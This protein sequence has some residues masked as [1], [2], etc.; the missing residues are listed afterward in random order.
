[1]PDV[2]A[3]VGDPT[4]RGI[5]ER[6][7]TEGPLS[8]SALA[9]SL[10]MSRQAVTKHLD[11]LEGAGLIERHVRGRERMHVL[12]AHPLR[13]LNDWLAPYEAEWDDRLARLRSHL[14]GEKGNGGDDD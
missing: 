2:F 13:E 12:S 3:A 11:V 1:M 14:A 8:V 7:R 9:V 5:L 10:P 4:R 6:L